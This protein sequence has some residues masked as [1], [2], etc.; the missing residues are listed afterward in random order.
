[1]T[2]GAIMPRSVSLA[3]IVEVCQRLC[4]RLIWR[5]WQR[6]AA[7]GARRVGLGP[8]CVKEYQA[9]RIQAAL[10]AGPHLT[11]LAHIRVILL[12]RIADLLP[13]RRPVSDVDPV[14]SAKPIAQPALGQCPAQFLYRQVGLRGQHPEDPLAVLHDPKH[15]TVTS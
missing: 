13:A 1:M 15:A 5:R 14:Q 11:A 6:G 8:H 12:A 4:G 2:Q 10:G 3:I 7:E 9:P